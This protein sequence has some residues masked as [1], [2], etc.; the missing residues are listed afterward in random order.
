MIY[1]ILV[2]FLCTVAIAAYTPDT[3][4]DAIKPLQMPEVA[5]TAIDTHD[6][7]VTLNTDVVAI[8]LRLSK[9]EKRRLI[10]DYARYL[11]K[12]RQLKEDRV[13]LSLK[14]ERLMNDERSKLAGIHRTA[15]R[16]YSIDAKMQANTYVL[17][18]RLT[19][20][21][22]HLKQEKARRLFSTYFTLS[23]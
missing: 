19:H 4:P 20:P 10:K 15:N 23:K 16:M 2:S 18:K 21:L 8:Q 9:K 3:H 22:S 1:P 12:Q 11:Q 13:V 6:H 5:T 14:L 17:L 7:Y